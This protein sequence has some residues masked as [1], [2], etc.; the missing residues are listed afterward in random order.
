MGNNMQQL[1]TEA[2]V[3]QGIPV[4]VDTSTVANLLEIFHQSTTQ[5]AANP[6]FSSLGH[7]ISYAE[8]AEL[9]QQFASYLQ[10]HAGLKPGDRIAIQLPNLIQYPVVLFGAMLAGLVVVNTNPLYTTRELEH[11]LNDSGAKAIVVLANV[12][13]PLATVVAKTGVEQVIVTELADLHPLPKRLMI[14][15]MAKHVKKMVPKLSMPNQLSLRKALQ[16]GRSAPYQ[17]VEV[18]REQLAVLQYTG[19][20]TGVAKGAM[21]SHANLVAN[22]MQ[23]LA[24]FDSFN[25]KHEKETLVLPLPLYHIYSFI[26]CMMM[27]ATGNHSVLVTNPRDSESMIKA[28]TNYPM[29]AFC[30]INTLFVQML[31]NEEFLK[32]EFPQLSMTLS[33]GMALTTDAAKRWQQQTGSEICQGYGLTETSPIVSVNPGNGNQVESIGLAVPSTQV[34]L[35]DADGAEVAVGERGELCVKG[36]QLMMGYWQRPEATAEVIDKDGWFHTGDVAL[37]QADGYLRIVD[38]LKDMIV[39]SGFN[40]YPNE[41]EDVLSEHP[42]VVECAAIG[43]PDEKSGE[44]VKMFVVLSYET[45]ND[46]LKAH[47][48]TGLTGYKVPSEFVIREELPKSSVGKILRRELR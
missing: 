21:L 39:V 5:Y 18:D 24:M 37:I 6:A 32:L 8:L 9:S 16:L 43:V 45:S 47:C 1:I 31:N 17:P 42:A 11:Q 33:G 38:R 7:T 14:N 3:R 2:L 22:C 44:R 35:V 27:M 46:E 4:S 34:K 48:K 29:T 36:P 25:F 30:G 41:L 10:H 12:A 13:A 28:M 20:T 40:V 26:N 19:G 23:G 15:L